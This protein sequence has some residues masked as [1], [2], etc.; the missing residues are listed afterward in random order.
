MKSTPNSMNLFTIYKTSLASFVRLNLGT[1]KAKIST[2]F[3]SISL[4]EYLLTRY[5]YINLESQFSS[6]LL[7]KE[8]KKINYH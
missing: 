6:L 1:I 8:N 7:I 2:F 5:L 3:S 4:F